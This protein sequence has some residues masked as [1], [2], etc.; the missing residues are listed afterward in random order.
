[1]LEIHAV[2]TLTITADNKNAYLKGLFKPN[3]VEYNANTESLKVIGE[4]P[5][6]LNGVYVR[7]THNQIHEPMSQYHPFDG[8]GM[9]HSAYFKDGKMEYRNRFVETTGLLAE[10][11]AG[12]SL[13]PGLLEPGMAARRGWGAIGAM[14][15]NAGT[16]VICHAGKLLAVMSQGSE[17]WRLDPITLEN[18]GPDKNWAKL[19]KDGVAGEFK[20]D[21]HTGDMMFMNYPETPPYMN[22]GVVDKHNNLVHYVPIE[23]PGARWPHDIGMTENYCILHDLPF[24]NEEKLFKKGI[25]KLKFHDDIAS[26]FGIIP[27]F[28]TTADVQWFEA[29]PCFILHLANCYEDCDEV[30][31]DGCISLNPLM[32]DIAGDTRDMN[33]KISAHLDKHN[34]QTRLHRWRFNLITGETHEE[35]LDQEVIEFPVCRGDYKGYKYRYAYA[36]LFKKGEWLMEGFKKYDLETGVHTKYM[37]GPGRY[38]S[39]LSVAKRT[40]STSEDDA[41][42]LTFIQDI[43]NDTSECAIFDAKN[44]LQGP[45]ARVMLPERISSGTHACWVDEYRLYGEKQTLD[46]NQGGPE[47][48]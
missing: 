37:Y 38:G 39:E 48:D 36:S 40:N 47:H 18:L 33:E 17:P 35:F 23:L 12:K 24:F 8:D 6:D 30:V 7:N 4:I 32:A 19:L 13:W 26:R 27:R 41:Y 3:A 20:V 16:D 45:I 9:L 15:D 14:K 5:V 46:V 10:K 21:E 29:T 31:M 2:T 11:A 28:G 34:T 25:R 22:Y 43:N 42:L 1:M 44:I